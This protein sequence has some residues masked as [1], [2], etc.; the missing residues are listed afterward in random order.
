[1]ARSFIE[2]CRDIGGNEYHII[3]SKALA[4]LVDQNEYPDNFFFYSLG[5]RPA[6]RVFSFKSHSR[7]L[8]RIED[9]IRPDAVFTTSGPAY[10]KPK[11]PHLVGYNLPHYIYGDSPFFSQLTFYKR[12][13]W[14]MKGQVL[15]YF[16]KRDAE[17]F[18]VQTDDVNQRLGNWL[19]TDK[20]LTVSNTY[21]QHYEKPKVVS[22][23]L[24][25]R[26]INEYRFLT[27]SAWYSHK[28]LDI[29]PKV[30]AALPDHL[31][32]KVRF[33]LTLPEDI[34]D[35]H[36]PSDSPEIINIGPVKPEEGPAL[37]EECDALFMPTLVECFSASYAEAMKMAKPILT[38]DLSF[39]HTVCGDAALYADPMNPNEMA[40]KII[41]LVENTRLRERLIQNGFRR[42]ES[43]KTARGRAKEYLGICEN[44]V[45]ERQNKDR[46]IVVVNQAT[47]Y[48]T[49]GLCN[50][51]AEQFDHVDLI[52]GSIH[53]Q[54]EQLKKTIGISKITKW[55]ERPASKKLFSYLK[56]CL[57]IYRLL[58]TRYRG[59]E[60]FFLSLPP[61]A[62][63]LSVALPNRYSI[64]IWDVYPDVF[65]ITGMKE[66][67][68]VYKIWAFLNR[69]VFRKANKIFTIGDRMA[70]LLEQYA[71]REDLLVTPI[72]SIFQ[73]NQKVDK[74]TNPFIEQ[75][76]LHDKFIVQY[77]GNIGLTHNVE[78]MVELAELMKNETG[79]LFQIIGRGPRMPNLKQLVKEKRLCN[80][81]FLPFQSDEMFPY[82]LSAADLG[83]VILDEVTARGSVPSK[84][85][86]LMSFGIPSLYIAP[87]ESQLHDYAVKYGHARCIN[88]YHLDEAAKFILELKN[89]VDLHSHYSR[90]A[91]I[92]ASHYRRSNADKI[93]AYYLERK[94]SYKDSLKSDRNLNK[95]AVPG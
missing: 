83:V 29:I 21:S 78:V 66:T 8:E 49:V 18:V 85:Y 41:E 30:F 73:S 12:L 57:Q 71:A 63:L 31:K 65:K 44:L 46:K 36:F 37:Y 64:L 39:A 88:H 69:V 91:L 23:K 54:G 61:M 26:E 16:F 93:V 28:N 86:N 87:E 55:V 67:H 2:E 5:Y 3:L 59:Y 77:S 47:N 11:A 27:L 81:Q 14:W 48:L 89:N 34:F 56:A 50:A 60:V 25:E 51:F 74:K 38:S 35:R 1:M 42:L 40:D 6:T 24:P 4:R 72:W 82:S 76:N 13:K 90:N 32:R 9:R 79:I 68:V 19:K 10:W 33:V 45:A 94:A 22:P 43:F 70:G 17:S 53:I 80:C 15:K 58:L 84:S 92:A 75:Q 20:I 7:D 95:L 62:Y 52:T